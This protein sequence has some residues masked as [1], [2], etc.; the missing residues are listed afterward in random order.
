MNTIERRV[1]FL[2]SSGSALATL[3]ILSLMLGALAWFWVITTVS[4][5]GAGDQRIA[6]WGFYFY[7]ACFACLGLKAVAEE[8]AERMW[9]RHFVRDDEAEWS[10]RRVIH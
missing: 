5:G 9:K 10:E 1:R 3:A 6:L 7:G 4:M 8:I 2:Q